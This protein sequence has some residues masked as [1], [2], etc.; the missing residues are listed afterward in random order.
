IADDGP[1]GVVFPVWT[2]YAEIVEHSLMMV[3]GIVG[4]ALLWKHKK[5]KGVIEMIIGLALLV[6]AQLIT[7]L[8]HFLIYPF[9][10]LNAI[11][12]HGLYLV[13]IILIILSFNKILNKK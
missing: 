6:V 10:I 2:Y 8:H 3:V 9:G 7:N 13:S 4:I 12:H 5:R 11:I 1:H